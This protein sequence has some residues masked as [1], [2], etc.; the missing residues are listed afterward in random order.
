MKKILIFSTAYLPLIG[1][2]EVA[3][4]EITDRLSDFHFDMVTAR[5][6]RRLSKFERVGNINIYRIGVGIPKFDKYLLAFFGHRFAQKLHQK[7]DYNAIWSIM[8]SYSGFAGMF[9]K[10]RHP[11]IP[12][13]L[14]LQEGDPI[15]YIK[16]RVRSVYPLFK[17]IFIK[18]DF[19]QTI[20][21]YLANFAREMGFKGPLEVVPNAV[22]IKYFSQQYSSIELEE[23]KRKLGKKPE[24]K[25]IITTSRLV[26]KNAVNDVI[27]SLPYLSENIKFLIVGTGPD[28]AKLKTL[29]NELKLEER[30]V[31]L[32]HVDHKEMPKYLKI[33]DVFIRPSLSEGLGNSFLE[34]MA[35]GIPVIATPVGGIPDF[36]FDPDKNPDKPSSGLFCEVRNP[37]SIAEKVKIF[38]EN[39]KL[40]EKIKTNAKELVIKNYDWDLIAQKMK[41]IF[42]RLIKK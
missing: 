21:H 34:A 15:E 1:G 17:R 30:V 41:D 19:I 10:K 16:R 11:K 9:F 40:T 22:D 24:D 35:A 4:K 38:L 5:I 33:S 8:A 32:G 39:Q 23:L 25:Y 29:T 28:E 18:A 7:K 42:S 13:L 27:K 26:L 12:F 3:V 37:K 2:A 20:S 6:N 31:F 14:T 36:L